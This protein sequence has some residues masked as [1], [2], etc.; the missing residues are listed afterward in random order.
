MSDFLRHVLESGVCLTVFYAIYWVFLKKETYFRLNRFYLVSSLF[1]SFIIPALNIPSPFLIAPAAPQNFHAGG[2]IAIPVR[3]GGTEKI[4]LAVYAAGVLLFLARFILHLTNLY[5][6]VRRNGIRHENNVSLVSVDKDFSPFSFLNFVFINDRCLT[7]GSLQRILAHERVHIHQYHSLDILLMELVIILQWFNP[8]VW[9]YKKSLQETHEYLADDGV[10]AQGFSVAMYQLLVFEQHVGAK[11]FEFAN[12][13]KQSQIK[14]R[15]TMMSKIKS[16][17]TAKLKLLLILPLASFLVLAFANPRAVSKV[18]NAAVSAPQENA[19]QSQEDQLR[20]Q[21]IAQAHEE[22]KMLKDKELKLREK[23]AAVEDPEKKKELKMNLS[24]VL[25]KQQRLEQFLVTAGVPQEPGGMG[26]KAEFKMLQEKEISIRAEL[27][28]ADDPAKQA[29][30]KATLAKL[31]KEYLI[32][33]AK[34]GDIRAALEKTA[35]PQKKAE[36]EDTL[37]KVLQKQAMLK[38]KAKEMELAEQEKKK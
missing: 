30:L 1:F 19:P 15:L 38:E 9:P 33:K 14:R 26:L 29:D 37:K 7:A 2:G 13:F 31:K 34:E 21:K 16:R 24:Q 6:V 32:L 36:L 11:L 27:E 22:L 12:N 35:D 8:F 17:N 4:L 20:K 18:D 3:S 25:E 10:I 23:L 5:A 28:K